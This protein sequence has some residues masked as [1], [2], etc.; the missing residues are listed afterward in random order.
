MATP[1]P[2]PPR[3]RS[4]GFGI[5]A[6]V[7]IL[8]LLCSA[9]SL[10]KWIG[11]SFLVLPRVVGLLESIRAEEIVTFPMDTTPTA[12]MFPR[13][14]TYHLYTSD[15]GLLEV[16]ASLAASDAT[17]WFVVMNAETGET[18][19][20]TYVDRG[21]MPYD[22]PRPSGRPI[23]RFAIP[24]AGTYVLSHP[25]REFDVYFVPDRTTGRES[26]IV[27]VF[28]AQLALLAVPV[29]LVFG[30]PWLARRRAWRNIN[31]NVAWHRR[32]CCAAAAGAVPEA[33]PAEECKSLLEIR[34]EPDK[35]PSCCPDL[36]ESQSNGCE[37]GRPR[38]PVSDWR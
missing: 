12:V 24:A 8:T 21:L 30:R 35:I 20:V 18:V 14:E 7:V 29:F 34:T 4:I 3:L 17:T 15:L 31:E 13:P 26:M 36:R 25:R 33:D 1:L 28:L 16:A 37:F 11:T 10:A 23:L 5:L 22:D 2:P 19:P 38:G 27:A 32:R 9:S 6:F